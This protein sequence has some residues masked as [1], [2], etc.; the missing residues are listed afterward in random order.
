MGAQPTASAAELVRTFHLLARMPEM[1][2]NRPE[3]WP[4]SYRF[5]L[6]G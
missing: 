4:L 3:L 6:S 5:R 2:R 1:G